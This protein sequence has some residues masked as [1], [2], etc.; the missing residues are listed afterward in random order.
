MIQQV[1]PVA[2][3]Q[4]AGKQVG[5]VLEKKQI[6]FEYTDPN[7]FKVFH[8]GHLMPNLVGQA[9]S[10][11]FEY[12]GADV[13]RVNYQ[14]DVGMHVAKS[15]YGILKLGGLDQV[16]NKSLQIRAEFLGK[17]YVLGTDDYDSN[18]KAKTEIIKINKAVYKIAQDNL[19]D[20]KYQDEKLNFGQVDKSIDLEQ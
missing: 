3:K 15:V 4:V 8:I 2:G 16:K 6:V 5:P 17:A 20:K 12:L 13:K 9:F 18:E 1:R 10:N 14:G 7:P 19:L 11:I